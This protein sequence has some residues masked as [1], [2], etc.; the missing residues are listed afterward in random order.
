MPT[1]LSLD[2]KIEKVHKFLSLVKQGD[3]LST[4]CLK[5][6]MSADALIAFQNLGLLRKNGLKYEF[7]ES[8]DLLI[9]DDEKIRIMANEKWYINREKQ[10]KNIILEKSEN[11][12][13][14]MPITITED[15]AKQLAKLGDMLGYQFQGKCPPGLWQRFQHLEN[16][17][18]KLRERNQ[19]LEKAMEAI[20]NVKNKFLKD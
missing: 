9:S 8:I 4:A 12:A 11:T 15:I 17:N 5:T 3:S 7:V 20:V 14:L 1:Q 18:K 2:K 6:P 13:P 19:E 10:N 16:E